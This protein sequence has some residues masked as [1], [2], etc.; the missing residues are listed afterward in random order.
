MRLSVTELD[1][2]RYWRDSDMELSEL[3]ARLKGETEPTPA[4]RAGRAFHKLLEEAEDGELRTAIVE[5]F[6][7]EF[8]VD[9]TID[10]SP[11][12]EL[13]GDISI[14][15]PCGPVTLVGV[16]DGLT[17]VT[18]RDYKLTERFDAERYA[19]SFQWR[20][21]LHMFAARTFIYDVF[22]GRYDDNRVIVY[23]YHRL[24]FH[25]Y[26]GMAEEV[27]REVCGLA[28]IVSTYVPERMAA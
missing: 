26:P 6:E 20:C 21:Y 22:V 24:T 13:K 8:A 16:V 15:T 28:E 11:I 1:S 18:V 23:D 4:M 27:R 12:R 2:Y 7:F 5:G 25:A 17:G 19:D 3:I 10:L 14:E 9:H